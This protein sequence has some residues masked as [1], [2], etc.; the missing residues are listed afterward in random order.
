MIVFQ[1]VRCSYKAEKCDDPCADFEDE[2]AFEG[3]DFLV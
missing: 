2:C 1:N 3:H